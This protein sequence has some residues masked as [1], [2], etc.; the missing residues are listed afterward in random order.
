[1][2]IFVFII[3]SCCFIFSQK[4]DVPGLSQRYTNLYVPSD[5]FNAQVKWGETFPPQTPF[6]INNPCAYH[7][8]NKEIDSPTANDSILEPSDADYRFSAKVSS[9]IHVMFKIAFLLRLYS[10]KIVLVFLGHANQYANIGDFVSKMWTH[11]S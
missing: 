1:M 2:V 9:L 4:M 8:M 3:I 11:Q 6:S 10:F 5:F 7:I